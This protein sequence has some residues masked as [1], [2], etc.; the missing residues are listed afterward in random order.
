MKE[1]LELA[2]KQGYVTAS[3]AKS[4]G[5]HEHTLGRMVSNGQLSATPCIYL[6]PGDRHRP[7]THALLTRAFLD[8]DPFAYAS[9]HSALALHGVALFDV[10]WRQIHLIEPLHQSRADRP[11]QARPLPLPATPSPK[12]TGTARWASPALAQVAARFGR[13][14]LVSRQRARP[15][16][17]HQG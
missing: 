11:P 17:V 16:A 9:H 1:I 2:K 7:D 10:P 12:S 3:Q 4:L 15:R 6:T 8:D 14:G 5:A 13:P